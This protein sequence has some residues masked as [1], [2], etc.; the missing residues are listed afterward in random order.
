MVELR[1][2]MNT[3]A[4]S[5]LRAK[6]PNS[7]IKLMGNRK[8][9]FLELNRQTSHDVLIKFRIYILLIPDAKLN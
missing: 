2:Y 8:P 6:P 7:Y 4:C 9:L 5:K 1:I 3:N